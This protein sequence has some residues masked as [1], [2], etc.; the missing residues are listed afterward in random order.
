ML[1]TLRVKDYAIIEHLEI[2]FPPGLN[3]LTGST[4]AG[5]SIL[6]GALGLILGEKADLDLIRSG[7]SQATVEASF[8]FNRNSPL[9][10]FLQKESL[11]TQDNFLIVRREVSSKGGSKIFVNDKAVTLSTLKSLGDFLVDLHGQHQ[12]QAL[13]D[14]KKH[15]D[16][17]DDF[18]NYADILNSV[19]DTYTDLKEKSAKLKQLQEQEK[20]AQDKKELFSFQLAEIEKANPQTGEEEKLIQEKSVLE[21]VER[22]SQIAGII[23]ENLSESDDSVSTRLSSAQK[24][25]NLASTW[26]KGLKEPLEQ[27]EN[28]HIQIRELSR[29]FENYKNKLEYDPEKLNFIRE[30]LD[31]LIKLKKKYGKNVEE[32]LGYAEEIRKSLN[33]LENRNGVMAKLGN[34][35]G[36]ITEILRDNSLKL[37]VARKKKAL[38]L[39]KKISRELAFLG[40][41]KTRFEIQMKYEGDENG[42]VELGGEKYKVD[43][44]G[45]DQ[46]E[47][48]I[49]PNLG[50]E[51]K[52][53][54]KI[55]SGGEISRMMLALKSALAGADKVPTL[56]FD[57]IDSGIGGEVAHKAGKKLKDLSKSHQVLAI[58][59]LQQIASVADQHF[60]VFK[61]VK[62][63]RTLTK[64]KKLAKEE[65]V[66]EIA[67]M[68]SG[69][70][71]TPLAEKQASQLLEEA[72]D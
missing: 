22:L 33:L 8:E 37:S 10:E 9:F 14:N 49:S 21:N 42:L 19:R 45:L 39:Q 55:A 12:H 44:K 64:I 26:D 65:R 11:I 27:L 57:E 24:E 63:E 50:E 66:S 6:I 30:R 67:R 18:G 52:P 29:F 51:V 13:L 31:L 68:L 43:E 70:K 34:E 32:I 3:I 5:K 17:L 36:N 38:E 71:I 58:T 35:I 2:D 4:G 41:E 15:I 48:L 40:M 16:F 53:L 69:K 47:F 56:I 60:K 20:M 59:H 7:A 1:K 23:L 25:L 72:L 46:I 28:S 62:G 54:T 61:E